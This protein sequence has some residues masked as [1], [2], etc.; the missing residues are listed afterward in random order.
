MKR[1]GWVV[2]HRRLAGA[3]LLWGACLLLA[4]GRLLGQYATTP[5]APAQREVIATSMSVTPQPAAAVVPPDQIP[6]STPVAHAPGAPTA[7]A[8]AAPIPGTIQQV[9]F[10]PDSPGGTGVSPVG[11]TGTPMLSPTALLNGMKANAPGVPRPMTPKTVTVAAVSVEVMGPDQLLLS[12]PLA[13]EIVIRNTGGRPVA[14]LHVEEPLPAGARALKTKPQA[15]ARG[16]RLVWDLRNL[17]AGGE[18]HLK[19][20]LNL[21][22]AG[23]LDLRPYVTFLCSDGLRTRVTRPPFSVE[24]S[25]DH[26]KVPRGGRIRF[27]IH[28][29]NHGDAP[30]A[31]IKIYDTLPSGL[32]HPQGRILAIT[33]FGNLLPGETRSITLET[34]AVESGTFRN[35]V[36]AQADG[37]VEGRAG[38]D[39]VVTEPSLSLRVDGPAQT[40]TQREIDFHLEAANPGSLPAKNVRLVQ[41]LPPTFEVVAA[42][43]GAS[44]DTEQHAL[45]WSL[46]DLS[47]GQRQTVTFRVKASLAGDWP[48]T[49]AV[50]SQNLP[51]ARATHTLR[52][53]AAAELKL[54]VRAREERLSVGEETVF[55]MH[56]FNKGDAA[57]AGLR[58]TAALPEAVTPLD[59]QGPSAGKI[60][61]QQVSFTPLA[62]L[63]AHGDVVYRLRVRGRQAGKGALRVELTAEKQTPAHSEISIQVREG[64]AG[65]APVP[66]KKKIAKTPAPPNQKTDATPAPAA[67]AVQQDTKSLSGE[68][69]R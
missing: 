69:L 40:V 16:N 2:G 38:L 32:H 49:A 47:A 51:E 29:A 56:V 34:T 25:A 61:K 59:A 33:N 62:Q 13:Y 20:E 3:G 23:E 12:K 39:V 22:S 14:E 6:P 57:C 48:M 31:N 37:G 15:V 36:L 64:P 18:R 7:P 63:D 4:A 54:E 66:A 1:K 53:E 44:L 52:A 26:D 27:T 46:P 41:T 50:L 55:R 35:E 11:G 42:S 65:D 58:L 17:E 9:S 45:V 5:S 8:V 21:A 68:G 19:V 60:D 10:V 30:V 24:M 43:R 67:A 28:I